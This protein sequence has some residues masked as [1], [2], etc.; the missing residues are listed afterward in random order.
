MEEIIKEVEIVDDSYEEII[1]SEPSIYGKWEW[2][3]S[4]NEISND[5][6]FPETE[7]ETKTIVI[8]DNFKYSVIR[9]DK[10]YE[11]KDYY[12]DSRVSV[13]DDESYNAIIINGW[14]DQLIEFYVDDEGTSLYLIDNFE[15]GYISVY[16]KKK[17]SNKM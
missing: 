10:I 12:I 15:D 13:F 14:Y 11:V 6:L 8:N 3:E 9:N 17:P 2:V 16:Y 1:E 7:E 5:Y 4:Y